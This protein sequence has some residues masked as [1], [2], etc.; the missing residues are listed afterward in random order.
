MHATF[1]ITAPRAAAMEARPASVRVVLRIWSTRLPNV[2]QSPKKDDRAAEPY[3]L[4]G[5]HEVRYQYTEMRAAPRALA[6]FAVG[7]TLFLHNVARADDEADKGQARE[8]GNQALAAVS[9]GDWAKAETL[10]LRAES[11][12]HASSLVLGLARARAHLG[13]Y[14]EAWEDYHRILVETLPPNASPALREAVGSAREEIV[15]VEGKRARVTINVSGSD[16]P[17]VTLDGVG[18]NAAALGAERQVNP[19]QHAVHVEADGC[20]PTDTTFSVGPGE[21][22]VANVTLQPLPPGAIPPPSSSSGTGTIPPPGTAESRPSESGGAPWKTIGLVGMGVGGAGVVVG[23][24]AGVVAIGKHNSVTGNQCATT[25]CS[26]SDF[27]SYQSL[28]SSY[29]TV[30]AVADVGFIAGGILAAA[31]AVVFFTAH[32]KKEP[33]ASGAWL[34]PYVGPG[35]AGVVGAF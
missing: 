1:A 24:I 28:V 21:G 23:A 7:A 6:C 30:G 9:Q 16:H 3:T 34:T 13:K 29:N 15:T 12:Y 33:A 14:V 35:N 20:S 2:P 10:F 18:I 31:G 11:L 26:S 17:R 19:G 4:G 8:L 5:R 32:D 25:G 22:T 27:S